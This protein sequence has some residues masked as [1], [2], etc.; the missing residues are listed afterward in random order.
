MTSL[1]A[2]YLLS[3]SIR[4]LELVSNSFRNSIG[5][6]IPT[7]KSS[8]SIY[9]LGSKSVLSI[10]DTLESTSSSS[11]A[12]VAS[13]ESSWAFSSA[14]LSSKN[15]ACRNF[16]RIND[17]MSIMSLYSSILTKTGALVPSILFT[18][19]ALRFRNQVVYV[20]EFFLNIF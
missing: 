18:F 10:V 8:F 15:L 1:Y 4:F 19:L 5:S 14:I 6:R 20:V 3:E 7:K 9:R 2:S 17:M 11:F 12:Q 13:S 16:S